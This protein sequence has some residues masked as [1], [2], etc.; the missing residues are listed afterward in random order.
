MNIRELEDIWVHIWPFSLLFH[1]EVYMRNDFM[2][3]AFVC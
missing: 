2:T 1:L 3:I